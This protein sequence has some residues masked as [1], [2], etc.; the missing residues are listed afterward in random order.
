MGDKVI[1]DIEELISTLS[2]TSLPTVI[3]EGIDDVV[4]YRKLED[5]FFDIGLSVMPVYGRNN[6]IKIFDRRHEFSKG[7]NF[8]FIADRDLWIVGGIP[9]QYRSPSMITTDGYSIENDL[10]RD[11]DVLNLL[12]GGELAKFHQEI[13]KIMY[14]Y[15]LIV[16][17]TT[18]M[19]SDAK[20]KTFIGTL[21]DSE[22]EYQRQIALNSG[23]EYPNELLQVMKA[24]FAR[25]L[26]G[27]SLMHV[28]SRQLSRKNRDIRVRTDVFFALARSKP[29]PLLSQIYEEVGSFFG[30]TIA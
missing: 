17:R 2:N 10:F 26:R 8:A 28:V 27:K 16:K 1:P 3:I 22:A 13:E 19:A 5:L 4:V 9:E 6:V 30:A 15:A 29:G 25:Y 14:W 24:D 18:E 11:H 20:I 7:K 12:E 21:L 23:E